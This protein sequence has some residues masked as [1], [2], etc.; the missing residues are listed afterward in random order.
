[1]RTINNIYFKSGIQFHTQKVDSLDDVFHRH[2]FFE[3]FYITSGEIDHT[4]NGVTRHLKAGDMFLLRPSD[5]HCFIRK[6]ADVCVHR[7]VLFPIEKFKSVCDFISPEFYTYATAAATPLFARLNQFELSDFEKDLER[8][9]YIPNVYLGSHTISPTNAISVKLLYK[10]LQ[11]AQ[12]KQPKAPDWIYALI[13]K[14]NDPESFNLESGELLDEYNYNHSYAC[15][16]FKKS[17]GV[18]I[19]TYFLTA[20]INYAM[21]LLQ[22]TDKPVTEIAIQSGFSSVSYFNRI[23]KNLHGISPRE[24]RKSFS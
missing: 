18:S 13:S 12:S 21:S 19:V 16:M 1:M 10:F 9:Q 24:Y 6:T 2:T 7:D 17:M 22:F 23:F 11:Y 3:I 4:V 15:R 5:V 8:Y 20:K 14:M